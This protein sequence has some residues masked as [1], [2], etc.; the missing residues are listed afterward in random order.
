MDHLPNSTERKAK[1]LSILL[2]KK[3]AW[4]AKKKPLASHVPGSQRLHRSQAEVTSKAL[5][6]LQET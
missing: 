6:W 3:E 1:E 5:A 4:D 2:R